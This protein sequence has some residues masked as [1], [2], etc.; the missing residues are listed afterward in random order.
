MRQGRP[1][2]E[3]EIQKIV[4]QLKHTDMPMSDIAATLGCMRLSVHEINRKYSARTYQN[5]TRSQK[6]KDSEGAAGAST[7]ST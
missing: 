7:R 2:S 1:L 4:S 5:S 6:A 3:S